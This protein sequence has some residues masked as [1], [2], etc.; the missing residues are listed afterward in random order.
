[1]Y[2]FSNAQQSIYFP[3]VQ[4]DTSKKKKIEIIKTD[5]LLYQTQ[6]LGKFRKLIGNVILKHDDATMFCD[7]ALIDIDAKIMIH[8][9]H[10][11]SL[12]GY[13]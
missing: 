1:M 2:V 5:S 4:K 12:L 11:K 8:P 10:A 3:P 6:E 7:S 9:A 13:T